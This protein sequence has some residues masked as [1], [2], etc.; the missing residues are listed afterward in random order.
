MTCP[1]G[2]YTGR[3]ITSGNPADAIKVICPRARDAANSDDAHDSLCVNPSAVCAL[4][5]ED[6]IF[7]AVRGGKVEADMCLTASAV[8]DAKARG[9]GIR[10]RAPKLLPDVCVG[11]GFERA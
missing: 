2:K 1:V 7:A 3:R 8:W 9:N 4:A 10:S 5:N 11:H 6:F